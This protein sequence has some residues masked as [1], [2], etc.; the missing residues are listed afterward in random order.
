[1]DLEDWAR[2]QQGISWMAIDTEFM[3][4]KTYF[5]SLC[6]VQVATEHSIVCIDPLKIDKLQS[7]LDLLINRDIVKILHSG[8]QD[9]EIFYQ[10]SG[11]VPAP[12]FDTQI[13][14]SL[15]GL[16]D[17]LAYAR[18]IKHYLGIDLDKS[19]TRTDWSARPLTDKQLEYAANDVRY[20]HEVWQKQHELLDQ[21]GQLSWL[22]EDFES[23]TRESLYETDSN[24][25]YKKIKGYRKL[26]GKRLFVL[27]KLAAWREEQARKKNLP[28]KWILA[29]EVMLDIGRLLPRDIKALNRIRGMDEKKSGKIADTVYKII[30]E[31]G[32]ATANEYPAFTETRPL[33]ESQKARVDLLMAIIRQV[34]EDNGISTGFVTNRSELEKLVT[35]G[36]SSVL[37]KGWRKHMVGD[38]LLE[39]LSGNKM[40]AIEDGKIILTD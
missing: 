38:L 2:T 26:Q 14:A 28:R 4:E 1:M 33:T 20:L 18:L 31:A 35:S 22:D 36:E 34:C 29:D 15:L 40:I 7:L 5:S 24:N 12:V 6:L 13:A 27:Q 16:G 3:R 30:R 23:L 9:L 10:L 39:V 21:R 11:K 17:Q 8:R 25:I 19:Q 32:E 37:L